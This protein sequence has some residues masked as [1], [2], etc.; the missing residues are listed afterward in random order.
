MDDNKNELGRSVPFVI[1][2]VI[3]LLAIIIGIP[4]GVYYLFQF[5]KMLGI[6]AIIFLGFVLLCIIN[7]SIEK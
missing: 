6:L 1:V 5:S 3:T 4:V 7:E 2:L